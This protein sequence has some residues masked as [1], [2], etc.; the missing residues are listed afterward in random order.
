MFF[1]EN[2][3]VRI[4]EM[5]AE[6]AT[7]QK[8]MNDQIVADEEIVAQAELVLSLYRRM[9]ESFSHEQLQ[10]IADVI[11]E[12]GVLHSITQYQQLQELHK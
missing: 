7:F 5:V 1:D 8:I 4:D 9:E 12:T 3:M 10:L 2:G 6:R 11:A